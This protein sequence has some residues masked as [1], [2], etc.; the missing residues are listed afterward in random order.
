M[1]RRL[2]SGERGVANL[3]DL[4]ILGDRIDLSEEFPWAATGL[5]FFRVF[6]RFIPT[7]LCHGKLSTR[8]DRLEL[9]GTAY[10]VKVAVSH[11]NQL[12]VRQI[13]IGSIVTL[14]ICGNAQCQRNRNKK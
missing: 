2:V 14:G 13:S 4:R 10:M 7:F 9:I 5:R 12:D 6:H 3:K 11:Q 8:H 1:A